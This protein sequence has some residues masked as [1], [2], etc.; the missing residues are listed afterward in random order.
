MKKQFLYILLAVIPSCV[1]AQTT[2]VKTGEAGV[3][4]ELI[5][6]W[7]V[8]TFAMT[9]FWNP[10]TGQYAGNAGEASR[11]YQ[12]SADGTAEEFFI[13]NSTSYNC[14]T[15]I[16]GYRKGTLKI[17]AANKSFSF[18][19]TTGYYR[20]A[21]CFNKEWKRKEYSGKD[22]C[23]QYQLTYYWALQNGDLLVKESPDAT[24]STVFKKI[25]TVSTK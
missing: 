25:N 17:D 19:P 11:S 22:L 21:N 4:K 7:Q 12:I 2:K 3:P 13:Y 15:Q 23:P 1:F 5:G 16:L 6:H 14:R 20:T 24:S 9:N 10:T 8:G 18:C